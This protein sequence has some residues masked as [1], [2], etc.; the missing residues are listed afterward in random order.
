MKNKTIL[1]LAAL[2]VV[3]MAS[4][5]SAART[6]GNRGGD[7]CG[8]TEPAPCYSEDCGC[9]YCYGPENTAINPA[10][11]PRTCNGDMVFEIAGF[12][13]N[14]HMDGMEYAVENHVAISNELSDADE[15]QSLNNLINADYKT[16]NFEWDFGFKAGIGYNS[17]CDG[18]DLGIVWTWYQGKANDSVEAQSDDNRSLLPLWSAFTPAQGYVLYATDIESNW[19]L[20]LNLIDL[21]LGREFWSSKYVALRPH[22][23]L[24]IAQLNQSF[25]LEHKGGSWSVT[26]IG[27]QENFNGFTDLDNDFKGVGV[28]AGLDSTWNLGCG[29]GIYGN[30]A[31]SIVYGRFSVDA[32]EYVRQAGADH[33]KIK[34]METD[35]SFRASRGMLDLGLGL[36]W[37]TLF[38]G[39]QYGLT[40]QLGWENHLF[41]NQNQLWRVNRIGAPFD[42]ENFPNNTGENVLSQRRGDL[43]TQGWTLRLTFE[44]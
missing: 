23:G 15:S 18:W 16:P 40:A 8:P 34:V 24:R 1:S 26:N 6:N 22:V 42:S 27:G 4:T 19:K 29:W 33:A 9:T 14:A 36:Q 12:Y 44:F 7:A 41:F 28:R 37:S 31:A 35:Y 11:R 13:W 10:V 39:C 38:C 21:D 30:F 3:G 25:S 20:K 17:A 2:S 32:N 43:D 5:L